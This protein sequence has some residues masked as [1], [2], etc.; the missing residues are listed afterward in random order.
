[1]NPGCLRELRQDIEEMCEAGSEP[2][3]YKGERC[4]GNS[5]QGVKKAVQGVS[6]I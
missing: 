1:M 5:S 4:V 2:H 6:G 3:Q